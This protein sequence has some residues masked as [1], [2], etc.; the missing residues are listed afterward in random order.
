MIPV[1]FTEL[2]A[3]RL[4]LP[5]P[6]S[7]NAPPRLRVPE[8][9]L[10]APTLLHALVGAMLSVPPLAFTVP[11]ELRL[12]AVGLIVSTPLSAVSTAPLLLVKA[13]GPTVSV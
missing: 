4:K 9:T 8:F 12:R 10:S 1:M 2:P 5:S 7:V 11:L 3:V 6:P 13:P